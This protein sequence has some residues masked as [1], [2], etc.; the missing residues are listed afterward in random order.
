[1]PRIVD[2]WMSSANARKLWPRMRAT[3]TWPLRKPSQWK[4]KPLRPRKRRMISKRQL[5]TRQRRPRLLPKRRLMRPLQRRTK[6]LRKLQKLR[7]RRQPQRPRKPQ[8][9]RK[10]AMKRGKRRSKRRNKLPLLPRKEWSKR[11]ET[12]RRVNLFAPYR[13]VER[14]WRPRNRELRKLNKERLSRKRNNLML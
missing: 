6:S 4:R 5:K 1:M 8:P 13:N 11:N 14:S 9:R 7:K 10:K 2:A 3:G 12:A